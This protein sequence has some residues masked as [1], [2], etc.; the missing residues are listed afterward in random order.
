MNHQINIDL[1]KE[2]ME[3]NKTVVEWVEDVLMSAPTEMRLNPDR[4]FLAIPNIA[5]RMILRYYRSRR[6]ISKISSFTV[7]A[8]YYTSV[9]STLFGYKVVPGYEMAI[10]LYF[11]DAATDP[12]RLIYKVPFSLVFTE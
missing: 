4:C 5:Q 12:E 10:V 9:F 1:G 2:E 7:P 11:A 3:V 8:S 6:D